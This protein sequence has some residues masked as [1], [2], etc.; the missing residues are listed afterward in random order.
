MLFCLDEFAA[1]GHME[2]IEK[3]PPDCQFRGQAVAGHSGPDPAQARLQGDLG[4][5][6]IGNAGLLT[7]FGNTDHTTLDHI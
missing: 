1:L 4:N 6:F 3:K 5:L 2:S 7:F